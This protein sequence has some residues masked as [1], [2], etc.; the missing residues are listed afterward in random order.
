MTEEQL[1]EQEQT[2]SVEETV[3]EQ[4]VNDGDVVENAEQPL[5]DEQPSAEALE[6]ERLQREND[7]LADKVLRAQAE[8]QNVQKRQAKEV[9]DLLKYK[10]QKLATALLPTVDSLEKA[11]T[12]EVSDEQAMALKKGVEMAYNSFLAALKDEGVEPIE[13]LH[14]KFDPT[15][16]QAIQQVA[17]DGVDSDIVTQE[18][19]KG[20]KQHDRVLRPSMVVVSQ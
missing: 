1:H 16:H 17:V 4:G 5:T 10:A 9:Q 14:Q 15:L 19:Q 11:L 2:Q 20:Y 13:A 12:V 18:F 3:D 8:L 6:I 7:A